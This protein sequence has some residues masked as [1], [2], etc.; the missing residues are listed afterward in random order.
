MNRRVKTKDLFATKNKYIS[1]FLNRFEYPCD[2][3]C[4]INNYINMVILK[5]IDGYFFMDDDILM[6]ENVRISPLA[7]IKGPAIIGANTEICAGAVLNGNTIIGE[8]CF[9][10]NSS[11]LKNCV[12]CDGVQL[13]RYN[14]VGY[15]VLGDNVLLDSSVGC[16]DIN[17]TSQQNGVFLGDGAKVGNGCALSSGT[18][19]LKN[20]TIDPLKV[21]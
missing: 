2:A 1:P 18:Y 13:K 9:I 8:N 17:D 4:Q 6:G 3:I 5:R 12:L 16:C 20:T 14:Y 7:I 21:I 10:G 15:S 19:V 11:E